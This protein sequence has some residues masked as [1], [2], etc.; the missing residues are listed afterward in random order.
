M[1]FIDGLMVK[2]AM[3]RLALSLAA[4]AGMLLLVAA[5]SAAP[6]PGARVPALTGP[7]HVATRSM[8]LTDHSRREPQQAKQ[9]RS[10]TDGECVKSGRAG[11][12]RKHTTPQP[13]GQRGS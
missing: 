13:Q 4:V 9:P 1:S 7:F 11:A 3:G 5:S 6:T 10:L 8:A 2:T 12:G